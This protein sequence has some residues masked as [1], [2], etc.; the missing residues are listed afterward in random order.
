MKKDS[1]SDFIQAWKN[2]DLPV[3]ST[4]KL[5]VREYSEGLTDFFRWRHRFKEAGYYEVQVPALLVKHGL[6]YTIHPSIK[7][8]CNEQ[9]GSDHYTWIYDRFYFETEK[10]A[11]L[12]ALRWL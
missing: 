7:N 10:D 6:K 2:Y 9:F 1:I 4:G 3:S 5:P 8:W 12:F 11:M